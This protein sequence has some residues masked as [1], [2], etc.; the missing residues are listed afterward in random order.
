M[1]SQNWKEKSSEYFHLSKTFDWRRPA[2]RTT[3]NDVV[4]I[5]LMGYFRDYWAVFVEKGY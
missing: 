2:Q 3:K 5:G 1:Q 4:E